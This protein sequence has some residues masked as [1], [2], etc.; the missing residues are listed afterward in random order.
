MVFGV[1]MCATVSGYKPPLSKNY[2][3]WIFVS[4]KKQGDLVSVDS[5]LVSCSL[6]RANHSASVAVPEI[7]GEALS[8][9]ID[10]ASIVEGEAQALG[11][12]FVT[13]LCGNADS[14]IREIARQAAFKDWE[15]VASVADELSKCVLRCDEQQLQT[16]KQFVGQSGD[17]ALAQRVSLVSKI[18]PIREN[19]TSDPIQELLRG[20]ISMSE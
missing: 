5:L 14:A 17:L 12:M 4:Q 13:A 1:T 15:P 18:R 20:A 9:G 8:L 10:L 3:T 19:L 2:P 6:M 16:V 7:S 11:A